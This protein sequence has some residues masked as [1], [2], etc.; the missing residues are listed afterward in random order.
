MSRATFSMA[1]LLFGASSIA[2]AQT[3]SVAGESGADE[4]IVVTG[5]RVVSDGT[6]VP[7]PLTVA[8]T[9]SL[10]ANAPGG[11]AEGLNQLPVFQGAVNAQTAQLVS[12]NRVRSGN[13]LNLRNLGPQPGHIYRC[14]PGRLCREVQWQ[15]ADDVLPTHIIGVDLGHHLSL[16][17]MLLEPL[18]K[19]L[20]S[21]HNYCLHFESPFSGAVRARPD[22]SLPLHGGH[23][24]RAYPLSWRGWGRGGIAIAPCG[25]GEP[26]SP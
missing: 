3:P 19:A 21:R 11:I 20:M 8:T 26:P 5:S 4:A 6:R 25:C 12:S 17:A 14:D 9:E 1:C 22:V 2:M 10:A 16:H 18:Y 15:D 24:T 23:K 7:T 13:Y